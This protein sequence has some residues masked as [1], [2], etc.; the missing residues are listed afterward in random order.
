MRMGQAPPP[1]Y[2]I[3]DAAALAPAAVPGAVVEMAVAGLRWIQL[4]LKT[5]MTDRQRFSIAEECCRRLKG[6][7][8]ELWIDDRVDLA[9]LLP[10]AGV[11]LGQDDLPPSAARRIVGPRVAIGLSTHSLAQV[12]GADADPDV[13]VVAFG[14][15]FATLSKENPDPCV[16]LD[17]LRAARLATRKPLVAI[18]GIDAENVARVL[19]AGADSAAAIRDV[20]R[21]PVRESCRFLLDAAERGSIR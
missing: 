10:F 6:R 20:S 12:R 16:G 9:T 11:H 2:A 21:E 19:A 15:V 7:E 4:R 5:A 18:G 13:D 1:I 8:V 17:G 3:A 14:P